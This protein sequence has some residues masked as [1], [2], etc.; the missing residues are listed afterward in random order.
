MGDSVPA[1]FLSPAPLL[2]LGGVPTAA[3]QPT[4]LIVDSG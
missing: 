3:Q 4:L 2:V 1:A